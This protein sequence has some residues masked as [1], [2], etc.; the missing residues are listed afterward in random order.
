MLPFAVVGTTM[1]KKHD[2]KTLR[3][4][5]LFANRRAVQYQQV[6]LEFPVSKV[7]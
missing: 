6:A 4:Q 1:E 7:S 5:F 3:G 2:D